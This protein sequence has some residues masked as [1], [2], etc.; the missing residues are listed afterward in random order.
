MPKPPEKPHLAVVTDGTE[1]SAP[2]S[3]LGEAGTKLWRRITSEYDIS[4][5]GGRE[6]LA[7]ICGAA[8]RVA[9]LRAVIDAD[10]EV[11]RARNGTI[12]QH[13]CLLL[14]IQNRALIMRGL[15]KLGVTTE[16]VQARGHPARPTEWVPPI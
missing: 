2:P 3:G 8:D 7:Q 10:G 14:E 6:L 9:S 13:P 5:A 12:K 11:I 15:E 1:G 4:D 16:P